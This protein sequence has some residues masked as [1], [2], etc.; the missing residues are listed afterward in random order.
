[1]RGNW[2]P[3]VLADLEGNGSLAI[4]ESSYDGHVYAWRSTGAAVPG[5]PVQV[6]VPKAS[7]DDRGE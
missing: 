5:W 1:M 2:S 4:I 6:A 7:L 3:P